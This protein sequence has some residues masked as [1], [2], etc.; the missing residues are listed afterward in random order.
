MVTDDEQ[1]REKVLKGFYG[2][3]TQKVSPRRHQN[4]ATGNQLAKMVDETNNSGVFRPGTASTGVQR[5]RR[6]GLG[7]RSR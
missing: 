6:L 7:R 1:Y 4:A 2:R 5:N 3:M